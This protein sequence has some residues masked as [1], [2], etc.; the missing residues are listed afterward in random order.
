MVAKSE[1]D[2]VSSSA[3]KSEKERSNEAGE[4]I[5]LRRNIFRALTQTRQCVTSDEKCTVNE[6]VMIGGRGNLRKT[7]I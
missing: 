4:T 1:Q 2:L 6:L 3:Y 5:N 7:R